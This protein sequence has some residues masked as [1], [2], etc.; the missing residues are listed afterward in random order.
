MKI[1]IT[2]FP[3]GFRLNLFLSKK[4]RFGNRCSLSGCLSK[5]HLKMRRHVSSVNFLSFKLMNLFARESNYTLY[6]YIYMYRNIGFPA[7]AVDFRLKISL[8]YS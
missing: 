6:I 5:I 1:K 2:Q 3:G 7:Q 4:I 8:K